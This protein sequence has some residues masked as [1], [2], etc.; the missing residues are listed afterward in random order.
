LVVLVD[1]AVPA[2]VNIVSKEKEKID[3]HHGLFI[4]LKKL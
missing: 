3:K 2:D 4:E 1:V